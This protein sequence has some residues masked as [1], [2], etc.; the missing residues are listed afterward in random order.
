M[1]PTVGFKLDVAP[2]WTCRTS[3]TG[4]RCGRGRHDDRLQGP[5]RSRGRGR[6]GAAGDVR[7]HAGGV[8]QRGLRGPARHSG[9]ASRCSRRSPTARLG[10]GRRPDR[11]VE[12]IG[13]GRGQRA[14]HHRRPCR[15]GRLH[16]LSRLYAHCEAAGIQM[17]NGGMGEP[18]VGRGQAQPLASPIPTRPTTSRRRTTTPSSRRPVCRRRARSTPRRTA[19]FAAGDPRR[20]WAAAQRQARQLIRLALDADR[21]GR[22]SPNPASQSARSARQPQTAI[23]LCA[24]SSGQRHGALTRRERSCLSATPISTQAHLLSRKEPSATPRQTADSAL[25]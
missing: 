1:N 24:R 16:E 2:S 7:A 13:R 3:W 8:H 12:S 5:V 22:S 19:V 18:G 25:S 4:S 10:G 23:L 6:G 20:L 15:V 17:Y 21:R 9:C 14:D 11:S